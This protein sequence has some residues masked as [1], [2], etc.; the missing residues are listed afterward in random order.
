[1]REVHVFQPMRSYL[2]GEVPASP[3]FWILHVMF[4]MASASGLMATAQIAPIARD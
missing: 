3:V 1:M 4:V 2:A